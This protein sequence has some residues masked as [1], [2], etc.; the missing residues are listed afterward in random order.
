MP[1]E[2]VFV[3]LSPRI[4]DGTYGHALLEVQYSIADRWIAVGSRQICQAVPTPIH[5]VRFIYP[6]VFFLGDNELK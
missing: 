5:A 2:A 3:I 4:R 1:V 6:E